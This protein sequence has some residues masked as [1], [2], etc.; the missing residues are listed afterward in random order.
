M[1]KYCRTILLMFVLLVNVALLSA[2]SL[3]DIDTGKLAEQLQKEF[4]YNGTYVVETYYENLEQVEITD[5]KECFYVYEI[6]DNS[7]F[8]ILN[9]SETL[10]TYEIEGCIC[11]KIE[12]SDRPDISAQFDENG[13][14][15]ITRILAD[16]T[17][18]LI[19][20][21]AVDSPD[22]LIGTYCYKSFR[23]ND[24]TISDFPINSNYPESNDYFEQSQITFEIGENQT[25]KTTLSTGD[26]INQ[27]FFYTDT[28]LI[29]T[30]T[31]RLKIVS[32][33]LTKTTVVDQTLN[34]TFSY[35]K[36][37]I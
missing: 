18:R 8:N 26:I 9:Q 6:K 36:Q 33:A 25:I 30:P 14:M 37:S 23:R 2:C 24:A 15:T 16:K 22:K 1:K 34:Y 12:F 32:G 7:T 19:C 31:Q 13:R 35:Q 27:T 21:R 17:I 5:Q 3:F 10:E 4:N 20:I 29:I 11:G 28:N